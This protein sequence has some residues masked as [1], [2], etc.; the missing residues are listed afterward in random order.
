[1]NTIFHVL[2]LVYALLSGSITLAG[3]A[4][5]AKLYFFPKPRRNDRPVLIPLGPDGNHLSS[6]GGLDRRDFLGS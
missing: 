3:I 6:S 5:I 1:M 4:L 2:I